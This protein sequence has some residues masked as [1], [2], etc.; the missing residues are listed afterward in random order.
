MSDPKPYDLSKP[1]EMLR[2][3]HE[4]YGYLHTSLEDGTDREGRCHALNA[5][6]SIEKSGPRWA[7]CLAACA[8][9]LH[10]N[11]GAFIHPSRTPGWIL[12]ALERAVKA[13]MEG[14]EGEVPAPRPCCGSCKF[15]LRGPSEGTC[16]RGPPCWTAVDGSAMWPRVVDV[17][18]CGEH[19]PKAVV[20]E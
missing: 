20:D 19:R 3:V 5:L 2:L 17:D 13:E 12:E 8:A 14:T 11:Q 4:V 9:I 6:R 15:C 16:H 1:E 7:S 10:R 18:W